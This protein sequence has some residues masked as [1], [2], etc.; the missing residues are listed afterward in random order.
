VHKDIVHY[1]QTVISPS[2]Q[3]NATERQSAKRPEIC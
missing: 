2:A 1:R 3:K